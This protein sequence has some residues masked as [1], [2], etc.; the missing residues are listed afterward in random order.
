MPT[1]SRSDVGVRLA[2]V[3]TLDRDGLVAEWLEA[4]GLSAQPKSWKRSTRATGSPATPPRRG[5][6]DPV[7][8]A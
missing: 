8:A 6:L 5:L 2:R 7:G 4:V 1:T 3:E